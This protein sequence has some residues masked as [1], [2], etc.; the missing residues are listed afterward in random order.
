M[1][2]VNR[3][4]S[5]SSNK[6]EEEDIEGGVE[7]TTYHDDTVF[8]EDDD[9]TSYPTDYDGPS[10][11]EDTDEETVDKG[12]TAYGIDR[13]QDIETVLEELKQSLRSS[14]LRDVREDL[15]SAYAKIKQKLIDEKEKL[16]DNGRR[17]APS[18]WSDIHPE[19][20]KDELLHE[21]DEPLLYEMRRDVKKAVAK[22]CDRCGIDEDV[23]EHCKSVKKKKRT[24]KS[25]RKRKR[26]KPRKKHPPK[27]PT[28]PKQS[29]QTKKT[30]KDKSCSICCCC[31]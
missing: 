8:E 11:I 6:S 31:C 13:I 14:K 27:S 15:V 17:R 18:D 24:S 26:P 7:D 22:I 20:I 28:K 5:R 2:G 19:E 25:K 16:D 10:Y 21:V 4:I 23:P 3:S 9:R 1:D 12:V 29:L 30:V